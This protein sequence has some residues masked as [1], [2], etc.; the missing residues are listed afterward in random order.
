MRR[1]ERCCSRLDALARTS[2]IPQLDAELVYESTFLAA[3]GN[4]EGLLAALLEEFVCGPRGR[5]K[6]FPIVTPKTRRA[7]QNLVLQG[8]DYVDY[9]PFKRMQA[10]AAFYLN[11]GAPF[12]VVSTS[13]V[14]LLADCGRVRNA[15]AHK[16]SHAMHVFRTKV[17]AVGSLPAHR[18][19]PGTFLRHAYRAA[20]TQ[21]YH[22]LY[23]AT[24]RRV[25][26]EIA[27]AW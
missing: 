6:C 16:T 4:F 17:N 3:M 25:G 23:V 1:L 9:L 20:P 8:R 26:Q 27:K 10:L 13:D 14:G 18:R 11:D 12:N 22:E 24:L 2:A 7:F 19:N 5:A 21:T 15:I